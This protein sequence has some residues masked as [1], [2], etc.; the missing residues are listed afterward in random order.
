MTDEPDIEAA[1]YVLG[2][3]PADERSRFAA[4]L[5]G[6]PALRAEVRFWQERLAALDE[7]APA[8]APPAS[9]WRLIEQAMGARAASATPVQPASNV[10]Q[11]R[12]RVALWRGA[13]LA[14]GALAA[15]LAG[16]VVIDR[17]SVAP[18]PAG[19]R[20][21][22]VVDTGGREPAL[23][24]EVNT[25]TGVIQVR[26][27]QAETPAGRSLELWH[28][29]EGHQPRSLGVLQAGA[30]AQTIQDAASAGPVDGIIAV[31]VEPQGGSPSGAP[32]GPVV[33]SGRL[34]PVDD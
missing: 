29:A 10:V 3:L 12:R 28:I 5:A 17:L 31:T 24:A 9:L 2:T 32:T 1:E 14:T 23:I 7:A 6:D 15:G 22:A 30:D 20:Y 4:R 11:L 16:F 18:E 26:S 25:A 13:A 34:I 21:V 27:L 19:G 33:Y 8:E